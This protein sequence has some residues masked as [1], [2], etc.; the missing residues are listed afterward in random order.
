MKRIAPFI[1]CLVLLCGCADTGEKEFI[2]FIEHTAHAEEV[3]FT[4]DVSARARYFGGHKG[5][6][7]GRSA[8]P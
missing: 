8:E 3:S 5:E 7:R 1:M 4:A 2:R 6:A